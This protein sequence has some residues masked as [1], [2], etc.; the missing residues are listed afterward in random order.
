MSSNRCLY[1]EKFNDFCNED[2]N[3]IFGKLCDGYHGDAQTT[4]RES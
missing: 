1:N 3:S 2:N 4:I